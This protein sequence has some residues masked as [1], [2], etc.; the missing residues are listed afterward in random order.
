MFQDL[1]D[2]NVRIV[3]DLV[4]ATPVDILRSRESLCKFIT[5]VTG[6]V[7]QAEQII[8]TKGITKLWF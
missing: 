2:Y 8:T 3:N 5:L 1:L 7:W 4:M 6:A